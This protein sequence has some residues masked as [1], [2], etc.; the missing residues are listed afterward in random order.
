MVT[1]AAQTS[2][3]RRKSGHDAP[4]EEDGAVHIEF[5]VVVRLSILP[6]VYVIPAQLKA[7]VRGMEP[8]RLMDHFGEAFQ[9]ELFGA[10]RSALYRILNGFVNGLLVQRC[11]CGAPLE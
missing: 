7:V 6:C 5:A 9:L 2:L 1:N 4:S 3:S 10:H 8:V 11:L